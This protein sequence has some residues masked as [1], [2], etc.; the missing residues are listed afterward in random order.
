[1]TPILLTMLI[2]G[3]GIL[4]LVAED[5]LPT[6]GALGLLAVACLALVLY[7]GFAESSTAGLRNLAIEATLVPTAYGLWSYLLAR[8]GVGRAA[9]L[10]PPQADE[11]EVSH[12]RSDLARLVGERGRAVTTLRPAGIVDFEG[13]RLDGMAEEGLIV[14]GQTVLAVR[15]ASGRLVVRLESAG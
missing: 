4:L 11:V 5:L 10:Q 1:M 2:L 14:T 9:R 12:G 15:V 7:Q 13:R 6:G 8:S 3:L